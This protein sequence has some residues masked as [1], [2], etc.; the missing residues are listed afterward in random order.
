MHK[1]RAE[2]LASGYA[3]GQEDATGTETAAPSSQD[4]EHDSE[5]YLLRQARGWIA[6]GFEDVDVAILTDDEV[7]RGV[8]EHYDGGWPAFRRA[9]LAAYYRPGDG[10]LARENAARRTSG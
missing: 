10:V 2:G 4:G 5:T 6:E 3:W 9:E 7:R 1:Y 8:D